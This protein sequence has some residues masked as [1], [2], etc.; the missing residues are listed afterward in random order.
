M[1]CYISTDV[2]QVDQ[3]H[4]ALSVCSSNKEPIVDSTSFKDTSVYGLC[5]VDNEQ[6]I[7]SENSSLTWINSSSGQKI[8][9]TTRGSSYFIS[10][11]DKKDYIVVTGNI[12]C[13]VL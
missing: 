5:F 6:F 8:K 13:H 10:T 11:S 9:R 3:S 7:V 12:R 2:I 1:E 4:G